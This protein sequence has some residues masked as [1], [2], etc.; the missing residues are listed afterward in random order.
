MDES[1]MRHLRECKNE[2]AKLPAALNLPQKQVKTRALIVPSTAG[3]A[4]RP[5]IPGLIC[6]LL[7][8]HANPKLNQ[9]LLLMTFSFL[10]EYG[11]YNHS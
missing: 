9:D 1:E 10:L 2:S 6:M 7:D 8:S 11:M 3:Y 5:P 4:L